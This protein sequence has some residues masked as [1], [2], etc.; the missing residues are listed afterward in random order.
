MFLST[1]L[2]SFKLREFN[3]DLPSILFTKSK[4]L[5]S[6]Y[7]PWYNLGIIIKQKG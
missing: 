7:V 3:L 1:K 6:R 2:S 4:L 5:D